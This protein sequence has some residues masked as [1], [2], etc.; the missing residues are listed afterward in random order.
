[1]GRPEGSNYDVVNGIG[2]CFQE[3]A[4]LRVKG[5]KTQV[6]MIVNEKAEGEENSRFTLRMSSHH[7]VVAS[8]HVRLGHSDLSA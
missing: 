1:M 7:G 5:R 6:D 3:L 4:M 8:R 2:A